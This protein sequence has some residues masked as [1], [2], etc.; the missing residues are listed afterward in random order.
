M[1]PIDQR[2]YKMKNPAMNFYCPLCRMPRSVSVRPRLKL[3]HYLNITVITAFFVLLFWNLMG[4][5]SLV[6][7]FVIWGS[8]EGTLRALFRKQ[9]P[10]PHCGFDAS[11][12]KKDVKVAKKLVSDFWASKN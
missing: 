9:V 8:F 11:W 7:F 1:K 2:T 3:K 5:G 6:W 10:C 4:V 12:Y